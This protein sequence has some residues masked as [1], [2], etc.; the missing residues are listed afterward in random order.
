MLFVASVL[1]LLLLKARPECLLPDIDAS[2]N[3]LE[4]AGAETVFSVR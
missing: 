1:C 2:E 4:L 3:E